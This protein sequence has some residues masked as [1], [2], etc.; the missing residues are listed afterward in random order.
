MSAELNKLRASIDEIDAQMLKLLNQRADVAQQ[1]GHLKSG[2]AYKPER[3]A[4]VLRRVMQSNPGPL[5][6]ETAAYL[7]REIM[8]ACL[9]LEKPVRVA[10]L[11]PV[12][13]STK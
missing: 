1:I 3:E 6:D 2:I 11:G 10:H 8:S 9:A 4:E 7:F 5:P 12:R 13:R